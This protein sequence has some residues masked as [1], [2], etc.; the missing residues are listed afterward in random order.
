MP[1]TDTPFLDWCVM[2]GTV[3]DVA[4]PTQRVPGVFPRQNSAP[5]NEGVNQSRAAIGG[6]LDALVT[7]RRRTTSSADHPFAASGSNRTRTC[8]WVSVTAKP[9]T[10]AAKH[11]ESGCNRSS[12]HC[13]RCSNPTPHK[14]ARRGKCSGSNG[15]RLRLRVDFEPLS[16]RIAPLYECI[17][18]LVIPSRAPTYKRKMPVLLLF[19]SLSLSGRSRDYKRMR[20]EYNVRSDDHSVFPFR[21]TECQP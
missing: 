12:I 15:L 19:F 20:N 11:L 17:T 5:T 7:N 10:L 14:N 13:L 2:V 3:V 18:T 21:K 4:I 1:P 6:F 16:S 8:K 9:Q